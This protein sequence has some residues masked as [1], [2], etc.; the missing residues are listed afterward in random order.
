MKARGA[1]TPRQSV[2]KI[3]H[4][5]PCDVH[6]VTFAPATT[7]LGPQST[8]SGR[9]RLAPKNV[10]ARNIKTLGSRR[11]ASLVDGSGSRLGVRAKKKSNA[12]VTNIAPAIA[13]TVYSAGTNDCIVVTIALGTKYRQTGASTRR[14]R[15]YEFETPFALDVPLHGPLRSPRTLPVDNNIE[16]GD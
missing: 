9:I 3:R 2:R 14:P 1:H 8:F 11:R 13:H 15:L 6:W 5:Q 10:I 4:I 16:E 12:P 7:E